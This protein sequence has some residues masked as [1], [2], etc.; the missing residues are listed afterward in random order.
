MPSCGG[1]S[2]RLCSTPVRPFRWHTWRVLLTS[3]SSLSLD[4][5]TVSGSHESSIFR[6]GEDG[7]GSR[8]LALV[9]QLE[10]M[11]FCNQQVG[12]SSPPEGFY[13]VFG[14]CGFGDRL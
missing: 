4:V 2:G 10:E 6:G 8:F 12:G 5:T 13:L 9:T 3:L 7:D 11:L 14:L 1:I